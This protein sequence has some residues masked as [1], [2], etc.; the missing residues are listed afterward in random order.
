MNPA[1]KS[2][3]ASILV[4]VVAGLM[5]GATTAFGGVNAPPQAET[6][7]EHYAAAKTLPAISAASIGKAGRVVPP[8]PSVQV[9]D[10]LKAAG[11]PVGPCDP[12]P[13][14][15][16]PVLLPEDDPALKMAPETP[17]SGCA[18]AL[19]RTTSSGAPNKIEGPCGVG[20]QI[21]DVQVF[22]NKAG[23]NCAET[24]FH[25]ASDK[26]D[27]NAVVCEGD[28]VGKNGLRLVKAVN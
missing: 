26:P 17:K 19:L 25:P 16:S 4:V 28:T 13:E 7:A 24:Q 1:R 21:T 15:G 5:A 22:V 8:C 9:V 11:L 18:V 12:T 2:A 3:R 6:A 27:E 23:R 10:K 20:A 14:N